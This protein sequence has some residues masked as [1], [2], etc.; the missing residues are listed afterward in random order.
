MDSPVVASYRHMN[1]VYRSLEVYIHQYS[2][3]HNNLLHREKVATHAGLDIFWIFG[4][5]C[6]TKSYAMDSWLSPTNLPT[7]IAWFGEVPAEQHLIIIGRRTYHYPRL[8]GI[9]TSAETQNACRTP[10]V[11]CNLRERN[12]EKFSNKEGQKRA[13]GT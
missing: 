7:P 3:P 10:T 13:T 8:G 9:F 5:T 12:R 1:I 4:D 11:W 6:G 2:I